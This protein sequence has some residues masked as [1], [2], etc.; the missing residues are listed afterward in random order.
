LEPIFGKNGMKFEIEYVQ[1][2]LW[3]NS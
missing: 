3:L 1:T 2:E